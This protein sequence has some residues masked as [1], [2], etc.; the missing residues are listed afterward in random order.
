MAATDHPSRKRWT[1]AQ[2]GALAALVCAGVLLTVWPPLAL[3]P[4]A[5]YVGLCCLAPFYPHWSW[6]LPILSHGSRKSQTVALT[7]DDGP[8]PRATPALLNLLERYGVTAT[9]FLLGRR[10]ARHPE[11]VDAILKAGHSVGNHSFSHDKWL[12]LRSSKRL[13][14]DIAATQKLLAGHGVRP[15][16]FRPP[17]G[18]TNPLLGTILNRLGLYAVN[19]SC[20]GYDLGNRRLTH[21]AAKLLDRVRGGDILLL[22]DTAPP[23]TADLKLWLEEVERLLTGLANKGLRVARLEDLIGRKVMVYGQGACASSPVQTSSAAE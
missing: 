11:L 3:L 2:R 23:R 22:H 7:F 1:T 21:L 8:D 9:F 4:L 17:V 6:Y 20:R 12:M 14:A 16:A 19:F 15:L 13:A 10:A 18:I 5:A